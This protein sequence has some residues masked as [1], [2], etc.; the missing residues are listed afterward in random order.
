MDEAKTKLEQEIVEVFNTMNGLSPDS[1]KYDKTLDRLVR[2]Y[3]LKISEDK[4]DFDFREKEAR[5]EMEER[6]H[7]DEV[8]AAYAARKEELEEKKKQNRFQWINLGASIAITLLT[9]V[10]SYAFHNYWLKKSFKFEEDG[11]IAGATSRGVWN[12]LFKLFRK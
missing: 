12:P 10:T 11:T 3:E 7:V 4:V 5:R 1:E 6:Q 9:G 2:L 8:D